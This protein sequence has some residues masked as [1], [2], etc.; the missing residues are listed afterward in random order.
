MTWIAPPLDFIEDQMI[1]Q[2]SRRGLKAVTVKSESTIT[3]ELPR[4]AYI[5]LTIHLTYTKSKE[6][7]IKS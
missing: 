7:S 2:F 6:V 1:V 4:G 5:G 3:D